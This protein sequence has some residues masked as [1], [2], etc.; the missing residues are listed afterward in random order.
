MTDERNTRK[1]KR[2]MVCRNNL[3]RAFA[4]CL[5]VFLFCLMPSPA[6]AQLAQS[7]YNITGVKT[8]VLPNA[9]RVTIQTDGD[10][11]LNIDAREFVTLTDL[12]GSNFDFKEALLKR[13]FRLRFTGAK[14]R[15]PAFVEVGAYPFDAVSLTL[16]RD[17]FAFSLS[18]DNFGPSL[19]GVLVEAGIDVELRFYV[20]VRISYFT[21]RFDGYYGWSF[22]GYPAV[23]QPLQASIVV[24]PDRRSVIITVI[25]DRVEAYRNPERIRRSPP[26]SWKHRLAITGG[27]GRFKADILHT[28][29]A[30]ALNEIGRIAEVNLQSQPD[31]AEADVTAFLPERDTKTNLKALIGGLGLNLIALPPEQG[32]GFTVGR[33]GAGL[34]SERLPLQNLSPERARLLFP[35]FLL[36]SL[37]ADTDNN[38]LI[39]SGSPAL[40]ERLKRDVS[41]LDRPRPQVTVEA[42]AYEFQMPEDQIYVLS[43][44]VNQGR[45]AYDT[46]AGAV[47][48][49]LLPGQQA[50]I[51]ARLQALITQGRARLAARP[52]VTAL[53]GE[54]ATLF[55]G[56]TRFLPVLTADYS[57]SQQ[58][59]ILP[60]LVGVTLSVQPTTSGGDADIL[61]N[62]K[63]KFSTVD[64]I[65]AETGLPVIGTREISSYVRVRPGDTVLVGGLESE[66]EFGERRNFAPF[67]PVPLLNDLTSSRRSSKGRTSLLALVTA[68]VSNESLP[69]Q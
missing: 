53:S 62:L 39:A 52:S 58:I 29:L 1:G 21:L 66:S 49:N 59:S 33:G 30:E 9:V 67:R 36:P 22:A 46:D 13:K 63:P 2:A 38:A 50:T 4:F 27:A 5:I 51:Q 12:G 7:F 56:Q 43:G 32:G 6:I 3:P 15:I 31:A 44:V 54:Q 61:L 23:L 17:P 25:T 60:L 28:P 42:Q 14:S 69:K 55:L 40:L 35:D 65:E 26:E 34:P 47:T 19:P 24:G 41:L 45:V 16:S 10:V 37:R 18:E 57:G 48:V 8:D 64:S 11:K 68:R 20:P